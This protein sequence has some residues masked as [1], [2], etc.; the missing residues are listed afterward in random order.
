[1]F[2]IHSSV[3]SGLP[4]WFCTQFEATRIPPSS[5]E[6]SQSVSN[7][8]SPLIAAEAEPKRCETVCE[9]ACACF[10]VRQLSV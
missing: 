9:N 1:M 7:T 2:R 8:K 6:M 4:A 3:D 10:A 5:P